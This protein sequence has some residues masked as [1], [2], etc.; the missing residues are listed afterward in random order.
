MANCRQCGKELPRLSSTDICS[1]CARANLKKTL[2][3]NPELKKAFKEA[4]EETF[5][6][7]T[8]RKWLIPRF[9]LCR[10]YKRYKSRKSDRYGNRLC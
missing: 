3:A 9:V 2:D 10:L 7:E 4:V 1:D 8:E 5:S 6:P